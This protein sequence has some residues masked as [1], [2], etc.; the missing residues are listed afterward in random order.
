MGKS[1]GTRTTYIPFALGPYLYPFTLSVAIIVIT[2]RKTSYHDNRENIAI[3]DIIE[4]SH[5]SRLN[6]DPICFL[7]SQTPQGTH[8]SHRVY[9]I[10]W[11]SPCDQWL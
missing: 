11:T 2:N 4:I 10:R 8:E 6:M 7:S 5:R 9:G 3:K 1:K